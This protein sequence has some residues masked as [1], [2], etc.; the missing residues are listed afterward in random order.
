[1]NK[2]ENG[3][4]YTCGEPS[5]FVLLGGWGGGAGLGMEGELCETPS[6]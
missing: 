3:K 5:G 2:R 4:D 6:T 1:M